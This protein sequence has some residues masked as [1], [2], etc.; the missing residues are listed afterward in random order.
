MPTKKI[1]SE[2][3]KNLVGATDWNRLKAMTDAEVKKAA[4]SDQTARELTP[5]ELAQFK[6]KPVL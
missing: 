6:R 1:S 2:E 3:A 4:N 5:F